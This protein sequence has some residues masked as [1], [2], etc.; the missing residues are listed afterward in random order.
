MA[1]IDTGRIIKFL[2]KKDFK[3]IREIGQGGTGRTVLLEDQII[4]ERFVCKKYSP[5]YEEYRKEFFNNFKE[6][7]KLL[8]LLYHKNIVRVFNYYLYPEEYTGYLIM[9][10]VKGTDIA[11]F[12]KKNPDKLNEIFR[13]TIDAFVHLEKSR[14]LHRDIRP[15][16]IL[17]SEDSVVKV[18]DFGFGK[19]IDFQSDYDK[20]ISLNWRYTRPS[21]FD[22]E[23]YDFK[24]EI[25]FLGRLFEEIILENNFQS[26]AYRELLKKMCSHTYENR[27]NSFFE[28]N[29]MILS[30]DSSEIQF[31][32]VE[33]VAY[34]QF[35]DRLQNIF[36]RI[37]A[38]SSYVTDISDIISKLQEVYRNS[39]LED[40]IQN[41]NSLA[42]VFIKGNYTY[43]TTR[44]F[45]VEI[46]L[47]FLNFL[48]SS[49]IEKQKTIL[50]NL[51]QRLDSIHRYD[52]ME[53][54]DLP[55]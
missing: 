54:D 27:V 5:L 12:L 38:D 49:S 16:N 48:K 25:Y 21:D 23:T 24:T 41:N 22:D 20:S 13:Q 3:F 9:E 35:A 32:P 34:Q 4:N 6:E 30:E 17:V 10:Y 47:N 14:I 29:R 45:E 52:P 33:K 44:D 55:F 2:R 15:E 1:K 7:I 18:I 37:N 39:I 40:I 36:V 51:W 43:N 19:K 31:T 28:L 46:L 50:N 53:D 11:S 8:H 26:F 42:N